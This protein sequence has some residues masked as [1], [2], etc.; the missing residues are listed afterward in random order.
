M[1]LDTA[2]RLNPK[3]FRALRLLAPSQA[4]S[5]QKAEAMKTWQKLVDGGGL[6]LVDVPEY[7]RLAAELQDWEI[8]DRLVDA[9]SAGAPKALPHHLRAELAVIRGN[10]SVAE[11]ALRRALS[12]DG[13]P[14]SRAALARFLLVH[15]NSP[16]TAPEILRLLRGLSK[17][18]GNLGAL[19][20][21]SALENRLVPESERSEWVRELLEHP[22]ATAPMLLIAEDARIQAD[23]ALRPLAAA[24]VY[25]RFLGKPLDSRERAVFWLMAQKEPDLAARMV[26]LDEAVGRPQL[27]VKWLDA[28][29]ASR[30]LEQFFDA[31]K[32]PR[33]PLPEVQVRLYLANGMKRAGRADEAATLYE[34]ILEESAADPSTQ[35]KVLAYLYLDGE[36]VLF[37]K[38]LRPL[39]SNPSTAAP[40]MDVLLPLIHNMRDIH[41]TRRIHEL[42]SDAGM[43]GTIELQNE[44]DY[45]DLILGKPV[46]AGRLRSVALKNPGSLG[47]RLT[48]TMALLRSGRIPEALVEIAAAENQPANGPMTAA[49]FEMIRAAALALDGRRAEA[50]NRIRVNHRL[51]ALSF[52]EK[53]FL[54]QA[55]LWRIGKGAMAEPDLD[56][57]RG[58]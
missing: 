33:N 32:D 6:I 46:E 16:E 49:R 47:M 13:S 43:A 34:K 36:N 3:N 28:L 51:D 45:C 37:E 20:L 42:G 7:A 11:E 22:K 2:L 55:L 4:A 38:G 52:Q 57:Q 27:F 17:D 58:G 31:L 8:A 23:P 35:S 21:S 56:R 25:A 40:A 44:L 9:V 24:R 1:A 12:I 39:L 26:T 53:E 41:Q 30:R 54:R 18:P 50:L 14:E 15:R 10:L 29:S 19:A 48:W 5:G